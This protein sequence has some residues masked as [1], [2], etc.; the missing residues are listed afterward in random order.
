MVQLVLGAGLVV[1]RHDSAFSSKL[2]ILV[3]FFAMYS[4]RKYTHPQT[5]QDQ[6]LDAHENS[7]KEN[8]TNREPGCIYTVEY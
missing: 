5:G 2:A 1:P 4:C 3:Y 8:P 6:V 7:N